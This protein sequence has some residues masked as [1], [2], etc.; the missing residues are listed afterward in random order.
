MFNKIREFFL[1]KSKTQE[2]VVVAPYKVEAPTP[3]VEVAP[4]SMVIAVEGAGLVDI[5]ANSRKT[6]STRKPRAKKAKAE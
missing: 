3:V 6:P 2:P 4:Q 5:P 1:G